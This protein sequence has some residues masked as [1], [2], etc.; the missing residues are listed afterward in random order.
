[1][2]LDEAKKLTNGVYKIYWAKGHGKSVAAIGRDHSGNAWIQAA[3]L[4]STNAALDYWENVDRVEL[5]KASK[6]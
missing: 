2:T 5:I 4:I 1:M 3:N 6:T